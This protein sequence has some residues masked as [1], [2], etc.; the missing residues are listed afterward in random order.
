MYIFSEIEI[1]MTNCVVPIAHCL[2]PI[3]LAHTYIGSFT[4]IGA[5][6][7]T[8]LVGLA[9]CCFISFI[10]RRHSHESLYHSIDGLQ[11][12]ASDFMSEQSATASLAGPWPS[13]RGQAKPPDGF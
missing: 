1:S 9:A 11:T 12:S 4:Y 10:V 2:L 13:L 5:S 7:H 3:P 8:F 6:A